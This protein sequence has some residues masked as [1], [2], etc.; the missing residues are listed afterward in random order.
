MGGEYGEFHTSCHTCTPEPD[1]PGYMIGTTPI[2]LD[3]YGS[4]YA[5]YNLSWSSTFSGI[6]ESINS[7]I[8]GITGFTSWLFGLC[9][10]SDKE[11]RAVRDVWVYIG[12][13]KDES[14]LP[15]KKVYWKYEKKKM[16]EEWWW[17]CLKP[18]GHP[19]HHDKS[20]SGKTGNTKLESYSPKTIKKFFSKPFTGGWPKDKDLDKIGKE[21]EKRLNR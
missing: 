18:K 3:L 21:K 20:V 14:Y 13:Y 2:S 19:P 11:W 7:A 16:S 15:Q 12:C 8:S 9:W 10:F 5:T 1:L 17:V 4:P 6:N